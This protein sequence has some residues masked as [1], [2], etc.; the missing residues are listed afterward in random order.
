[1]G[2][3]F[4]FILE[5]AIKFIGGQLFKKKSSVPTAVEIALAQGRAEEKLAVEEK[6]NEVISTASAARSNAEL[7]VVR[8]VGATPVGSSPNDKLAE[9]FPGLF[10]D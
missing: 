8:A 5:W 6:A 4:S 10:R 1:M 3:F 2:S 9:K 7:D